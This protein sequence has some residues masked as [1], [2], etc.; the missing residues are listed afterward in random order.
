MLSGVH[1]GR[2]SVARF[3]SNDK[4][5]NLTVCVF[6]DYRA[7]LYTGIAMNLSKYIKLNKCTL[8]LFIGKCSLWINWSPK[9]E[10][11]KS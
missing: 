10:G 8:N 4:P 7:D 3:G 5:T 11:E 6:G 1:D 9:V 2:T